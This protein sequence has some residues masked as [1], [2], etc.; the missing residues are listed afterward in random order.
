MAAVFAPT[1]VE[2]DLL[3]YSMGAEGLAQE[4]LGRLAVTLSS[5]EEV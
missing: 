1:L 5:E 2:R 3:G 4:A